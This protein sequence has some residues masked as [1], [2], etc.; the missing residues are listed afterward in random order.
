MEVA[1]NA[2]QLIL[3]AGTLRACSAVVTIAAARRAITTVIAVGRVV[4]NLVVMI[5]L[6]TAIYLFIVLVA[7]IAEVVPLSGRSVGDISAQG[8]AVY[9]LPYQKGIG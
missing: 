9:V 2:T 1:R 8:P 4:V 5:L 7:P 3:V 6:A